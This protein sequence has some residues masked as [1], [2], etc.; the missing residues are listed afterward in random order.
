MLVEISSERDRYLD[1]SRSS[2]AT[3]A[4]CEREAAQAALLTKTTRDLTAQ[5]TASDRAAKDLEAE[6]A[7]IEADRDVKTKAL[8][9][10]VHEI[11]TSLNNEQQ[12]CELLTSQ[13]TEM[14]RQLH[15]LTSELEAEQSRCLELQSGLG[16]QSNE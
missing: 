2:A 1:L 4:L 12:K 15:S 10:S 5:L 16:Q 13:A 6:K 9:H 8:E 14:E 11:K 3:A 7:N